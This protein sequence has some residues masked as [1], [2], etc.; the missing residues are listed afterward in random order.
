[1]N[2]HNLFCDVD[3][4][5][6]LVELL[7]EEVGVDMT[8][9]GDLRKAEV[10]AVDAK[11]VDVYA[12]SRSTLILF[13]KKLLALKLRTRSLRIRH[14][15]ILSGKSDL[16]YLMAVRPPLTTLSF[17]YAHVINRI[18]RSTTSYAEHK[19]GGKKS[20]YEHFVKKPLTNAEVMAFLG[21]LIL[22]GIHNVRNYRKAFSE[23]KAQV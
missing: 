4:L 23:S 10:V 12:V 2:L 14:H 13:Q 19:K 11:V 5:V 8:K 21:V 16:M 22:L 7:E 6:I 20:R 9:H 3:L 18:I 1:M 15:F 17:F